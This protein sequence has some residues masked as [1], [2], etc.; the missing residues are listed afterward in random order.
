MQDGLQHIKQQH[1]NFPVDTSVNNQMKYATQ[2]FL[3]LRC[4]ARGSGSGRQGMIQTTWAAT[5]ARWWWS[6][7]MP[8]S[9]TRS[10]RSR[11]SGENFRRLIILK[12]FYPDQVADFLS[13]VCSILPSPLDIECET[14][15][16]VNYREKS[17]NLFPDLIFQEYT[18]DIIE[19]IVNQ[20]MRPDQVCEA[21][22]LCP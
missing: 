14:M 17:S 16:T 5:C 1:Q 15:I 3:R 19:L 4:P 9:Q 13:G 8:S 2:T 18:D 7:W 6:S 11:S 12:A 20:Y 22:S 21:L 10:L